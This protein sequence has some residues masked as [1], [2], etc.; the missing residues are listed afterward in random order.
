M[1]YMSGKDNVVLQGGDKNVKP[2]S[3]F[4]LK[5][6]LNPQVAPALVI[7]GVDEENGS[8]VITIQAQDV[9]GNDLAGRFLV[10][11]WVAATAYAAPNAIA[12]FSVN[13]AGTQIEQITEKADLLILTDE[14]GKITLDV[15]DVAIH[16]IMATAGGPVFTGSL[17]VTN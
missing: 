5:D 16:H 8:G 1:T 14:N 12:D 10:R 4:A 15:E 11:T 3:D 17:E 9:D 6:E 2:V 13:D 7:T